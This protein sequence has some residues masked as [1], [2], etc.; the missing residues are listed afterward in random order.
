MLTLEN[1]GTVARVETVGSNNSDTSPVCLD[2]IFVKRLGKHEYEP[3][4]LEL[5]KLG[6]QGKRKGMPSTTWSTWAMA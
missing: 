4:Q 3:F 6:K 1:S 5:R 2:E